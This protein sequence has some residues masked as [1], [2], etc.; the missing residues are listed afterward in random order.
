MCEGFKNILTILLCIYV[1]RFL[2]VSFILK[3]GSVLKVKKAPQSVSYINFYHIIIRC[4]MRWNFHDFIFISFLL[5]YFLYLVLIRVIHKHHI[6]Y[7]H[8]IYITHAPR[9][10]HNHD[11]F[12]SVYKHS[13]FNSCLVEEELCT[14]FDIHN[15]SPRF[16]TLSI[17]ALCTNTINIIYLISF[18]LLSRLGTTT[19]T[20][21]CK[22]SQFFRTTIVGF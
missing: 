12:F 19:T 5:E 9:H 17:S 7:I 11:D 20:N 2:G 18:N 14:S 13:S 22:Y 3:N 8:I 6:T 1:K 4:R 10:A 15:I 16:T 21:F